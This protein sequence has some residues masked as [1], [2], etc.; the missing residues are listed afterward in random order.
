MSDI[1]EIRKRAMR[2]PQSL[3]AAE[4]KEIH[5]VAFGVPKQ[6]DSDVDAITHSHTKKEKQRKKEWW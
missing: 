2:D 3:S 1:A 6:V 5:K 4:W